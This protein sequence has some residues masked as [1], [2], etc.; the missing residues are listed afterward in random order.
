M[1]ISDN[2]QRLRTKLLAEERRL[3]KSTK[4]DN[5]NQDGRPSSSKKQVDG[6]GPSKGKQ[7]EVDVA[8]ELAPGGGVSGPA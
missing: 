7:R 1:E 4:P 3:R 2:Q 5:K 6:G 8:F